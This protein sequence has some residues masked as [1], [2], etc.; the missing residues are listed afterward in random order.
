[1]T[2]ASRTAWQQ[3][4]DGLNALVDAG[5]PVHIEPDGHIANPLGD[6]HIEWDPAAQRWRLVHDEDDTYAVTPPAARD[7]VA[8]GTETITGDELPLAHSE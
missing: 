8:M 7:L 2:Q 1:M 6:E 3:A 4:L 5:V